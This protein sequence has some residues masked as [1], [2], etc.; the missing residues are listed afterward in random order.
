[1]VPASIEAPRI[2]RLLENCPLPLGDEKLLQEQTASALDAAG[3]I[4]ERE[5]RLS[6]HDIVDFLIE[7]GIALEMKIKGGRFAIYRQCE[8]YC[9]FDAVHG[10]ILATNVAMSLPPAING[11]PTS[12]ALLGRGWL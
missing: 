3:L 4:F 10:L 5:R 9:G 7:D 6:P 2:V 12:V 11:K 8:R 1:M